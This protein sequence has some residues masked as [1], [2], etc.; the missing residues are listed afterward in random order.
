LQRPETIIIVLTTFD[1]DAYIIN[2]MTFGA[3]E[4]LLKDIGSEKLI[5]AIHDGVKGNIILPGRIASKITSR[6]TQTGTSK[7]ELQDFTEREQEIIRLLMLGK[8]NKEIA[9][10]LFLT[11]GTVKN[12]ISQIYSKA[13]V[14]DRANAVLFFKKLGL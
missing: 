9:E 13:E 2:A 3:S 14:T 10:T 6:I 7:T 8:S 5:E 4:Y 12:Y 1:D 11:V